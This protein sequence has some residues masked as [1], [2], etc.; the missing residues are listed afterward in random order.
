MNIRF[1][2]GVV[3]GRNVEIE[4]GA[5]V[6]NNSII[7]DGVSIGKGS[8][9]GHLV[10]VER[11]TKIGR[12]TTIQS[13]CHIT[14]LAEIGDNCFFGPG[15]IMT[16]EKNI[17]NQGRTTPKL[18]VCRVGNGVRIGAGSLLLPGVQIGDNAFIAAGSLV[19]KNVPAGE[20]WGGRP[21]R[22]MRE[23]PEIEFLGPVVDNEPC[24]L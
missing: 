8:V 23:V 15:V 10:V 16:N 18:E 9:I 21:A 3:I 6:W 2:E 12:N 14:A 17:A 24:P 1:G 13:Q 11:D 22:K 7:R 5:A 4:P 19:S 20:M